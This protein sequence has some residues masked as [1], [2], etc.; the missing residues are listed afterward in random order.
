MINQEN[1]KYGHAQT[2]VALS[3]AFPGSTAAFGRPGFCDAIWF[4][5]PPGLVILSDSW[6]S[7]AS[8]T[9][10]VASFDDAHPKGWALDGEDRCPFTPSSVFL[11]P[12]GKASNIAW[13]SLL[14]WNYCELM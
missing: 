12:A 14:Y 11:S 5:S 4:S 6:P 13:R 10:E 8:T 7:E 2:L 1:S 3:T 9:A